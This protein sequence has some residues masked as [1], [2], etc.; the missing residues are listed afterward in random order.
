MRYLSTVLRF[1][2]LLFAASI[3]LIGIVTSRTTTSLIFPLLF[4]PVLAYFAI[5]VVTKTDNE[6]LSKKS[7]QLWIFAVLFGLL[8]FLGISNL[9]ENSTS[10]YEAPSS[11]IIF[12]NQTAPEVPE[13]PAPVKT[14]T[15]SLADKTY[16]D[17]RISPLENSE[18]IGKA[19][20]GEVIE[21]LGKSGF[22]YEV[23]YSS[24]Q[25]GWI[26]EDFVSL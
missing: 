1:Y 16:V 14:L 12:S 25:S 23:Q 10:Q 13:E 11:P 8:L 19:Y 21:Y 2:S 15:I 5:S 17:I 26:H 7:N 4:T 20:D 24:N 6:L 18:S 3:T 22:W 9:R